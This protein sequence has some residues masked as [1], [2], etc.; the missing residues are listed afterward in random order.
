VREERV[1]DDGTLR[2]LIELPPAQMA[3][4]ARNPA[5]NLSILPNGMPCAAALPYLE[6][7]GPGARRPRRRSIPSNG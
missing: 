2:L 3:A 1:E 5:V 7:G 4:L 6:S